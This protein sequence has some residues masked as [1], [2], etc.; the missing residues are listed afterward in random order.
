MTEETNRE[1]SFEAALARLD[2]VVKAL[3]AGELTLDEAL[4]Y[5]EEGVKLAGYCHE[6]LNAA[7]TKIY[8][9]LQKADGS[10]RQ[11]PFY[12]PEEDGV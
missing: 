5:F 11:K 4:A 3:E 7:E 2:C 10:I 12:L 8:T 6:K 1:L 9:L